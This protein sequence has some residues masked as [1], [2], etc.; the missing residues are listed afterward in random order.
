MTKSKMLFPPVVGASK[1]WSKQFRNHGPVLMGT[2]KS[3][4]NKALFFDLAK[5]VTFFDAKIWGID[6]LANNNKYIKSTTTTTTI[7]SGG[8]TRFFQ[9]GVT[10]QM[11]GRHVQ[12]RNTFSSFPFRV[13]PVPASRPMPSGYFICMVRPPAGDNPSACFGSSRRL[14]NGTETLHHA[15]SIEAFVFKVHFLLPTTR[16]L[17]NSEK[18]NLKQRKLKF[19]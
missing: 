11:A 1:M 17:K 8:P 10:Q 5:Y 19:W 16:S 2:S 15:R 18:P 6:N 12:A 7:I 4:Q 3:L 13:L 9:R 14:R